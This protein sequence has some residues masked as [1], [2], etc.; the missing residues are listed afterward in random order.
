LFNN[1]FGGFTSNGNEYKIISTKENPTPAPWVNLL[2]NP[3]FGS[4]ISETGSAYTWAINAHEYR[5]TPW[6]NDPI[7][8]GGGEAFYLRDQESGSFWSP[9]PFPAKGTTPYITTHGFGYSHFEHTEHGIYSKMSVF[10]DKTLP[11]KFFILK[12]KNISGGA[13]KLMAAGFMEMILGDLRSKTNPHI[14][15]EYNAENFVLLL[16]NRYNSVFADRVTFFKVIGVPESYTANRAEFIGRNRNLSDPQAMHRSTLS[17]TT[18]ASVDP[19]AAIQIKIDLYNRD[20]KEIIFMLGNEKDIDA[21]MTLISKFP[22]AD[23]VHQSFKETEAYWKDILGCIQIQT[24]D[25]A[26]NILANGWLVYQTMASRIF[27]RSGFY[28]SGGAWGF[29]DQLQDVLALLSIRPEMARQQILLC[30]SRQFPEGDVQHWWNP[31]EGRGVRTHFSDDLLWL[32]YVVSRYIEATGDNSLLSV[33]VGFIESR[34]LHSDEDSLFDLPQYTSLSV[35]L[36]EHCVKAINHSLRFGIHGLPLMGTGDWNDGMDRVGNQGKGESVWLAFFQYDILIHFA[37]VAVG[38]GDFPFA[39]TCRKQAAILQTGIEASAWDGQWYLRAWFDDGTPLGSSKNTECSIDAI[40]QSWSVLSGVAEENRRRTAMASLEKHLVKR[41]LKLIQLLDP[42]FD[43]G[44]LNPGYI[45]GYVPGVREN[46]GQYSHAAIWALMAFAELGEREK[47]WD[48]FSMINPINHSSHA[49]TIK[50]YMVE[51]YVMAAD[52]YASAQHKGKGG[53]TWYTGSAG[54]MYQFIMR[55]LLG[56][57]LHSESLT[58]RPCFPSAWP[59]VSI[60]YLYKTSTYHITVFQSGSIESSWWKT[61]DQTGQGITI[62]LTD[63]GL[64]HKVEVHIRISE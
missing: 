62:P 44:D 5:L 17:D 16:R 13:R 33:N 10:V 55:S 60:V 12:I 50:K 49:A 47:V 38:F 19:C 1:G 28:Q 64:V 3:D 53:W 7:S 6:G 40:A 52:V 56:F 42:P 23:A 11:V 63:D 25:N 27:A 30:A 24:P 18:G 48:L 58:F 41:N 36:F 35:S 29:R 26:L 46:G 9:S 51:P 45:K 8:D 22:N 34:L 15:S 39:D 21:A 14:F 4:V 31:P 59:S 20:E 54:W 2:A 32:P 61:D 43:K 57:E 37:D